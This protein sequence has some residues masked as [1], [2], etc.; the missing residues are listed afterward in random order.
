MNN[1]SA[2][3]N[4]L[5]SARALFRYYRDL[6]EKALAQLPDDRIHW[7][8]S[9]ESNSVAILV[10]H[11]S[12]NMLS[13]FT[14]FLSTDGEKPWRDRD[15]EFENDYADK[16][17]LMA[18]WDAGWDCLLDA[19]DALDDADLG[20]IVYIRN[21]GHTVLEALNRQLCHYPYHVGQLIFLCKIV[22]GS[23]WQS[24]SIPKG[25]SQAFNEEKFAQERARR[26]FA[27]RI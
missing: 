1:F 19:V 13:R 12:G 3:E 5:A 6:G 16:N 9:P 23:A 15:A 8:I 26:F 11:L 24:L 27:D 25:G 18:A 21:Q 17:Q 2:S 20:R 14:D 4:F 22:S 7:Q 10:K